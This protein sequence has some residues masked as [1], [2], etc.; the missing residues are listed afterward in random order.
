MGETS[1]KTIRSDENVKSKQVD[2]LMQKSPSTKNTES[3]SFVPHDTISRDSFASSEMSTITSKSLLQQD[4]EC[5]VPEDLGKQL[6]DAVRG[7]YSV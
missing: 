7:R 4:T 5:Y 6:I 3:F 1:F 2:N